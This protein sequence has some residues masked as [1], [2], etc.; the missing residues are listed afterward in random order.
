LQAPKETV[1][2]LSFIKDQNRRKFAAMLTKMDDSIGRVVTALQV[3]IFEPS[4]Q[5]KPISFTNKI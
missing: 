5:K 4:E 3:F 2:S 1:D